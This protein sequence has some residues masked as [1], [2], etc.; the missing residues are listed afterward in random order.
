MVQ[1]YMKP[2]LRNLERGEAEADPIPEVL[3]RIL[4]GKSRTSK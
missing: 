3:S 4:C 2:L 1:T